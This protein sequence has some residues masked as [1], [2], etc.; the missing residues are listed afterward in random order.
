MNGLWVTQLDWPA[1]IVPK[2]TGWSGQE[3]LSSSSRTPFQSNLLEASGPVPSL[4]AY[5]TVDNGTDMR[6]YVTVIDGPG[7]VLSD[8]KTWR[9]R[10]YS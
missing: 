4:Q 9:R 2:H 5:Q 1:L 3:T 8:P 10:M 7:F 6:G